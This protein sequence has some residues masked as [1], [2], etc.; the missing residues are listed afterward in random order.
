MLSNGAGRSR[1]PRLRSTFV[2]GGALIIGLLTLLIGLGG[3][4]GET[5]PEPAADAPR[6]QGILAIAFGLGDG[7]PA[8]SGYIGNPTSD[9]FRL[10]AGR[11]YIEAVDAA[12]L[13]A[14][15]GIQT[16]T[17]AEVVELPVSLATA[18][19]ATRSERGQQLTT[20]VT[21]L[22]VAERAKLAALKSI[23]GGFTT[24]LFDV[25][26]VDSPGDFDRLM[27]LFAELAESQADTIGAVDAIE[28]RAAAVVPQAA[29]LTGSLS[30][31]RNIHF[32]VFGS[33]KDTL[34]GFFGYAGDAGMRARED[35]INVGS[36]LNPDDKQDAFDFIPQ[37]HRGGAG[38]F[39]EYLNRLRSGELD[40]SAATVRAAL[41]RTSVGFAAAAQ[42][43]LGDRPGLSIAHREGAELVR[44]GAEL[45][46]QVIKTVLGDVFPG[47]GQG[48]DMADDVSEWLEYVRDVYRDP[49]GSLEASAR[50]RITDAL[51]DRIKDRLEELGLPLSDDEI[52]D[53]A[54]QASSYLVDAIPELAPD[55]RELLAQAQDTAAAGPTRAPAP[56][57]P[58]PRPTSTPSPTAT[59]APTSAPTRVPTAAAPPR[60]TATSTPVPA[61]APAPAPDTSW[62][63]PV[64]QNVGTALT[65][66]SVPAEIAQIFL[67]DLRACLLDG[68]NAGLSRNDAI[69]RCQ[70]QLD[71]STPPEDA[72]LTGTVVA[73][74]PVDVAASLPAESAG[75]LTVLGSEM[76]IT[77][78]A[79]GGAVTGDVSIVLEMKLG[80]FLS[81]LFTSPEAAG[82]SAGDDAAAQAAAEA[83]TA[84]LA[85]LFART[86]APSGEAGETSAIE[87]PE[88]TDEQ[89]ELI[90]QLQRC[91][92][93]I[94]QAGGVEGVY[95]ATGQSFTGTASL[96]QSI[97]PTPECGDEL[98]GD[99]AQ[100]TLAAADVSEASWTATLSGR[101][102][103]GTLESGDG[104]ASP[105]TLTAVAEGS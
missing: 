2:P 62:V 15:L 36:R 40:D 78:P 72:P 67:D 63:D 101:T 27:A 48:F 98:S 38:D 42:D 47:I 31:N 94:V 17:D 3:C 68:A 23:S 45:N 28:V 64:V 43:D 86:D 69:G 88:L 103:T 46:V 81:A 18:G 100:G 52:D 29:L 89:R 59:A 105:F 25:A 54:D 9:P 83:S 73:S 66:G 50:E 33:I 57:A 26:A 34:L 79:E 44:R 11:Y 55:L 53:L 104:S 5:A 77:F 82:G 71:A 16:A 41:V 99:T 96:A 12:G 85:A 76:Q 1:R 21:A 24:E 65:A 93:R 30:A 90:D 37:A 58:Q 49:L 95:D 14:T 80:Q 51:K 19:G 4:G 6:H 22:V 75:L 32:G 20:V 92:I 97:E 10:P 60:P 102:V 87:I 61:P 74:G 39:D 7:T 84:L 8:L 91:V 35:I 13:V 70:T 56:V